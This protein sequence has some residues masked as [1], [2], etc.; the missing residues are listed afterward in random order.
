MYTVWIKIDESLPWIELTG[1]Y[2]TRDG[3]KE[4]ARDFRG[5]L[6]IK[7]VDLTER[8]IPFKTLLTAGS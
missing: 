7:I 5:T 1:A 6:R 2:Q 3:A 8:K 4:A